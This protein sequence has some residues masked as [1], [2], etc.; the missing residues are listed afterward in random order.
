MFASRDEQTLPR[1]LNKKQVLEIVP[2]SF[3]T[4]WKL[5]RLNQFPLPRTVG[6]TVGSRPYWLASEISEWVSSRPQRSYK[7]HPN[8]QED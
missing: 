8:K 3:P 1:L 6:S 5:M 7:P 4:L 2:L